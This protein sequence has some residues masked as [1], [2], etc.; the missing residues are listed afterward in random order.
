M[1][2]GSGA[3]GKGGVLSRCFMVKFR[4][5]P[6]ARS[7]HE[8]KN[9]LQNAWARTARAAHS[10][11]A[12]R[13]LCV[14][15]LPPH[16]RSKS[17][18]N[19]LQQQGRS[20]HGGRGRDRHCLPRFVRERGL[21][22]VQCRLQLLYGRRQGEPRPQSAGGRRKYARHRRVCRRPFARLCPLSGGRHRRHAQLAHRRDRLSERR[23]DGMRI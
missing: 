15:E 22:R 21:R 10:R 20:P 19:A 17:Q 11:R 4:K 13:R 8:G 12:V 23:H 3:G 16:R 6:K 18:R 14:R 9:D 7:Y 5:N 2:R 1:R